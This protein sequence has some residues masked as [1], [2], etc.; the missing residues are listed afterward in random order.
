MTRHLSLTLIKTLHTLIW[1]FFNGVIFY[2]LYAAV[3]GR[4]DWR[5]WLGYGLIA[6][7]GLVLLLFRLRCPLTVLARRYSSSLADNF[8]IYL[9]NWLARYNQ[10][11]YSG[12]VLLILLITAYQ[13]V[14]Q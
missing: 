6:T 7:E 4:L 2:M 10:R 8:D 5:L 11:I 9:P 13:L 3:A 12:I 1:L 14:Q